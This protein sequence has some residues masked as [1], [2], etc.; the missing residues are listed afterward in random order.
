MKIEES[1]NAERRRWRRYADGVADL[2]HDL[3]IEFQKHRSEAHEDILSE[4]AT[5]QGHYRL[6]LSPGRSWPILV[7]VDQSVE[8]PKVVVDFEQEAVDNDEFLIGDLAIH[9]SGRQLAYTVDLDGSDLYELRVLDLEPLGSSRQLRSGVGA[10]VGWHDS[11]ATIVFTELDESLRPHRISRIHPSGGTVEVLRQARSD[12][13]VDLGLAADGHTVLVSCQSHATARVL[14][15]DPVSAQ[16]LSCWRSG[17]DERV[18]LDTN[19]G[20]SWL[21]LTSPD[22]PDE[23]FVADTELTDPSL[24]R[25]WQ[26]RCVAP[27]GSYWDEVI[28][29]AGFALLIERRGG[30][31][32]MWRVSAASAAEP[33]PVEF[34]NEPATASTADES[35]LASITAVPGI[36]A[37]GTGV[38]IIR[39]RW[40]RP[41]RRY[42][43]SPDGQCAGLVMERRTPAGRRGLEPRMTVVQLTARSADGVLIP[44]TVLCPAGFDKPW[45]T[46]LYGYGAYGVALDPGYSPFRF[47]LLARGVA[48]AIAHVRGGGDLGPGWHQ[49]GRQAGKLHAIEDYLACA[50]HLI[51][52]GWSLRDGLV[53]RTRSAGGAVV[54]AAINRAPELFAAAVLEVPFVDCLRTLSDADAP[55]T[56]LE[57]EEWGNPLTDEA[58]RAA[59]AMFSPVDNVRP[60]DYPPLLVTAGTADNR[61][62]VSEPWR[63]SQAV[64]ALSTSHHPVLLKVDSAGHLGHSDLEEDWQDE[65]DVLSFI[66]DQ[67]GRAVPDHMSGC[68]FGSHEGL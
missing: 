26:S 45:P 24:P 30:G 18:Q 35:G 50:H 40:E 16:T 33:R 31:Q 25:R 38:E 67:L 43:T 11:T 44:L 63:Y 56:A 15:L 48:F 13:Y 2:Q 59:L 65:A 64:R 49:A 29:E 37:A 14:A 8:E 28:A 51:A 17:A 53:A 32:Q 47:S 22:R 46:V 60:A 7:R 27:P 61:V 39:D 3:L 12:E 54:G 66:L 42:R 55:L 10:T 68:R 9:R 20:Y 57:W 41:A 5:T 62:L 21:L 4:F 19:A 52:E 34:E 23:L 36:R 6:L 58:A 1:L